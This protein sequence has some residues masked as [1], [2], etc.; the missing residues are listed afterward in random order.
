MYVATLVASVFFSLS[1]KHLPWIAVIGG[2]ITLGGG[3][4]WAATFLALSPKQPA[5][6]VF[7]VFLNNSGY[8]SLGWVAIMSFYTPIYALYGTDG[9]LH[10][11]EEMR[12]APRAAPVRLSSNFVFVRQPELI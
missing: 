9:I 11:V 8:T 10:I 2:I 4:A 1:Q 12:D 3:I 7:G 5:S 6:F